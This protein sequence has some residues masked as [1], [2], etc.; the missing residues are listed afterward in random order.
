MTTG[1][2]VIWIGHTTDADA[3]ADGEYYA[4]LS[5]NNMNQRLFTLKAGTP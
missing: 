1:S 5:T 2:E 3:T 4:K